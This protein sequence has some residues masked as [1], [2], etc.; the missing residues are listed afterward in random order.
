[1]RALIFSLAAIL[2]TA[3]AIEPLAAQAPKTEAISWEKARE[4]VGKVVTVEGIVFSTK[5]RP[6]AI[7]LSFHPNFP[8]YF[9]VI[10]PASAIAKWKVDP[11]VYYQKRLVR[12]TGK[13]E[14]SQGN[15][16]IRLTDPKKIERL[17]R[18]PT[19]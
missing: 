14:E 10:I 15:H 9:S 8:D 4:N 17:Q 12:V 18:K 11:A 16:F 3:V 5:R 7:T 1:V 19:S 6:I 13:V 2:A